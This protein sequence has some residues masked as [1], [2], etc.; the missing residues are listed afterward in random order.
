MLGLICCVSIFGTAGAFS[1]NYP[2]FLCSV[3]ISG[4]GSIG[5]G[6]T[7]FVWAMEILPSREKTI[8][9]CSHLLN[10]TIG[11]L[12][13]ALIAYL[14]PHWRKMLIAMNAPFVLMLTIYWIVLESPRWL[15]NKGHI[16]RATVIVQNISKINGKP[17]NSSL[18]A[19]ATRSDTSENSETA[20]K[21]FQFF[22]LF[23]RPNLR[24]KTLIL[25]YVW[26]ANS[27]VYYGLTLNSNNF[28]ASVFVYFSIGKGDSNYMIYYA[29]STHVNLY[30]SYIV[31]LEIPFV[32]MVTVMALKTGRRLLIVA[33]LFFCGCGLIL[34]IAFPRYDL[35]PTMQ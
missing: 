11:G 22:D 8:V 17:K 29:N 30:V 33:L 10:Y 34:T 16:G 25:Y 23:R 35:V 2:L 13:V 9:G 21:N 27:F 32:L 7:I 3:W 12:F 14:L 5:I 6:T 4:F 18:C 24:K 15:I 1:P 28:G 19:I 31:A 20:I 26:F